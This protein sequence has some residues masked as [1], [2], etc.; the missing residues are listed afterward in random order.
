LIKRLRTR[1]LK[2]YCVVWRGALIESVTAA[3]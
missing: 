1:K 3:I 2:N